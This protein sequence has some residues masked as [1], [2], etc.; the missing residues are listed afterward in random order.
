MKFITPQ[1]SHLTIWLFS[2]LDGGQKKWVKTGLALAIASLSAASQAIDF[3]PNGM[4]SLNGFAEVTTGYASNYCTDCQWV[5]GQEKD[6]T[7]SD[8]L[9]PGKTYKSRATYFTQIQPYLGAK[10]DL[11]NGYKVSGLLSQRWRD[12]M[13]DVEGFWYEKNIALSHEDYGSIRVGSMTTRA[14]SVADYPYGTNVGLSGPWSSSGAAYGMMTNAVRYTS[15]MLDAADGDL[16]L[17]ATYDMGNTEFKINKPRFLE[18]YAQYHKG[19]LV[20]D[21]MLQDTQNGT[22]S[23][24][25]HGPFTGL[26]PFPIEDSVLKGSSQSMAMVM[27]RYQVDSKLEV[28]GGLRRNWWSGANAVQ[29]PGPSG[30]N[31][32]FNVDWGGTLNGVQNPGYAASSYDVMLGTRYRMGQW[33]ASAGVVHLGTATTSNPSDRGQGNSALIGALGLQYDYG[34]GLKFNIQSGAVH[35]AR[36]GIAPMSM[37]SNSAFTE[38]DSRVAQDG[39]WFTVGMVYGF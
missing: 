3:G 33:V 5:A 2:H 22:P 19:D 31:N 35:Y 28:S 1:A 20:V 14:W 37:P 12:G 11:G 32:M 6:K 7:W 34:N 38:V 30:W 9:N 26:T 39:Q 15:R 17:E 23:A 16:V 13:V 27:A 24:W 36:L 21:A 8:A 29:T 25:A 18:L 10:Y 4:F